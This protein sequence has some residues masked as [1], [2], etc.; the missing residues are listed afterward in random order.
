MGANWRYKNLPMVTEVAI[1]I[2]NKHESA[3]FRNIVFANYGRPREPLRY[4]RINLNHAAYM[5]LHYM[6]LFP[7][8][9]PGWH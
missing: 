3:S 9:D 6:L 4:Y 2:P 1:V 8:S 5:P 7:Y